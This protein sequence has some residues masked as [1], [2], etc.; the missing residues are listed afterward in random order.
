M[1]V[2]MDEQNPDAAPSSEKPVLSV[3]NIYQDAFLGLRGRGL[4]EGLG[5]GLQDECELKI[6]MWSLELLEDTAVRQLAT[7]DVARAKVVVF[8]LCGDSPLPES[9]ERWVE[10]WPARASNDCPALIAL[11]NPG[12]GGGGEINSVIRSYLRGVASRQG[13]TFFALTMHPEA[14]GPEG[15]PEEREELAALEMRQLEQAQLATQRLPAKWS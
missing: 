6:E 13:M 3:V 4:L 1:K 14:H 12:E 15:A 9:I 11:L 7:Q 5:R 8:S 2:P 10:S